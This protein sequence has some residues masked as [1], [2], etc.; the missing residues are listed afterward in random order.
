MEYFY[1]VSEVSSL[2]KLVKNLPTTP[3]AIEDTIIALI[4]KDVNMSLRLSNCHK[5]PIARTE[6]T[7]NKE[8]PI[9]LHFFG[10]GF[11]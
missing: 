11:Q 9:L 10:V 7:A 4:S 3:N 1:S 6:A 2:K 5:P 8:S